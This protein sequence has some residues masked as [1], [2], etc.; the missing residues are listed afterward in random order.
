MFHCPG[1]AIDACNPSRPPAADS[2]SGNAIANPSSF[3][4]T[5]TTFT[6]TDDLSPPAAKYAVATPPPIT[7]PIGFE[8]PITVPNR[9]DML[10]S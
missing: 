7:Q 6:A 10:S 2:A 4:V 1:S 3:T 9:A 5:C 8:S